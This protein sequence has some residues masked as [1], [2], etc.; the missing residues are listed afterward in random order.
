MST[1]TTTPNPDQCGYCGT[2]HT[3]KVCSRAPSL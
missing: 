3:G 1:T 2:V